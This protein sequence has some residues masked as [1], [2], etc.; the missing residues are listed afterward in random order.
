MLRF[1]SRSVVFR[2]QVI[3]DNTSKRYCD[4]LGSQTMAGRIQ[5]NNN[6]DREDALRSIDQ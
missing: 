4:A 3:R 5:K 2:T 6:N 1:L